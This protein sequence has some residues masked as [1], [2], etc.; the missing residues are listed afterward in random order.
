MKFVNVTSNFGKPVCDSMYCVKYVGKYVR[1]ELG[2]EWKCAETIL[3]G[4]HFVLQ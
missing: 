2:W 4:E 3:L 1:L